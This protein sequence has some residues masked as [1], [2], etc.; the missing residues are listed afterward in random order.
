M[1]VPDVDKD[2]LRKFIAEYFVEDAMSDVLVKKQDV[3]IV[4]YGEKG[5]E[6]GSPNVVR[7]ILSFDIYVRKERLHDCDADRMRQ[8]TKMIA[9]ILR[10]VLTDRK[11]VQNMQ[12]RYMDDY[13]LGS[14]VV[15]YVRHHITFSYVVTN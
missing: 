9:Q 13:A 11:H 6:I 2:D 5:D 7:K 14:K 8:R 1:C 15:G 3:M 10:E 4:Y 12:F